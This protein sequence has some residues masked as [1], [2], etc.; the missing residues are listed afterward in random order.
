M[1][2]GSIRISAG[3]LFVSCLADLTVYAA[4]QVVRGGGLTADAA[5]DLAGF[6]YENGF[7]EGLEDIHPEERPDSQLAGFRAR[8]ADAD[9][10]QLAE[11]R[12]AFSGSEG[13]L[14]RFAPVI[15]QFK[16]LDA[17]IVTNS[18]RFRWTDI[19]SQLRR[20][21]DPTGVAKDW[22]QRGIAPAGQDGA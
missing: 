20:R 15:D 21:I 6:I 4:A 10:G 22:R 11:G 14:I 2:S 7:R 18:I 13:D 12:V 3:K 1:F 9:W 17:E 8:V 16:E 19:R 5:A